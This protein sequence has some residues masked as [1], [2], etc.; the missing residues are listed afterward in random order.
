MQFRLIHSRSG[1]DFNVNIKHTHTW[2]TFK[3]A[4][5]SSHSHV[6]GLQFCTG[7]V[8][9]K[10]AEHW[11][12]DKCYRSHPLSRTVFGQSKDANANVLVQDAVCTLGPC[13]IVWSPLEFWMKV[14]FSNLTTK[15]CVKLKVQWFICIYV[16]I[17]IYVYKHTQTYVCM[18]VY[19]C[20]DV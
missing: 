3:E 12:P 10:P 16:C 17:Y 15:T 5:V 7:D 4:S 18:Y 9:L 19:V 13:S 11:V 14:V 2:V 1:S 20:M 6:K 8:P